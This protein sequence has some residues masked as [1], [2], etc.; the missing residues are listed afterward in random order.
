[1][2][3]DHSTLTAA[4]VAFYGF[5]SLVPALAATVSMYGLIAAPADVARHVSRVFAVLPDG[6][7]Q[8]LV[9]QLTRIAD[10][11]SGT[12]GGSFLLAFAIALW[13]ASRGV[14]HL[15]AAIGL[16]YDTP[17]RGAV[18]RRTT[19]VA[20][21]MG[22]LVTVGVAVAAFAV[23]PGLMPTAATRWAV[24]LGL[25]VALAALALAG[26]ELT[27]RLGSEQDRH[28]RTGVAAGSLFALAAL[29]LVTVGTNVYVANF[30]AYNATYGVLAGVVVLM[31]WVH[32]LVLIVLVGAYI[33]ADL[34]RAPS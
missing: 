3:D 27:Y 5:L 8:V 21:T 1:M 24:R 17:R 13:S 18:S 6:A 28:E 2:R 4:G 9:D 34:T 15:L 11:P 16:A 7:R 32:L 30:G 31:L 26:I 12:L 10:E 19:A 22:T 20:F 14:Q 25:W 29:V 33:N 23:L